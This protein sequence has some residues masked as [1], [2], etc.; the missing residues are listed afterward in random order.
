[1]MQNLDKEL[2]FVS[3]KHN[4]TATYKDAPQNA[5]YLECMIY[6][7]VTSEEKEQFQEIMGSD[8]FSWPDS[9]GGR[10]LIPLSE[11]QGTP[12][13]QLAPFSTEGGHLL[14]DGKE[15]PK[16]L[17]VV[18]D[19]V[20]RQLETHIHSLLCLIHEQPLLVSDTT[21]KEVLAHYKTLTGQEGAGVKFM[22]P[23]PVT[24]ALHELMPENPIPTH[25]CHLRKVI[26]GPRFSLSLKMVLHM[27]LQSIQP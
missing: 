11:I 13:S 5:T 20:V 14:S 25:G 26:H 1:M 22:G 3:V 19:V 9:Y 17:E 24:L 15:T 16:I 27:S 7:Q 21:R 12:E 10:L 8:V 2:S 4:T 6:P 18:V 23:D